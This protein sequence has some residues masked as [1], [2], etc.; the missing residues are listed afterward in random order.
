MIAV[1]GIYDKGKV[2]LLEPVP[3]D[4]P[5]EL[6]VTFLE[7]ERRPRSP[8]KMTALDALVGAVSVRRDGARNHDRYVYGKGK[9]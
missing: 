1:R 6:I 3:L 7:E 8:R 5:K 2:R 4:G 9:K